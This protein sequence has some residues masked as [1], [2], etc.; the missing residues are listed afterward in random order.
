MYDNR[1][2]KKAINDYFEFT[3][4]IKAIALLKIET[5]TWINKFVGCLVAGVTVDELMIEKF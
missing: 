3:R 2:A 5:N 4:E 1:N